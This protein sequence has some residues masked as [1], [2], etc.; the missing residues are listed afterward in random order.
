MAASTVFIKSIHKSF[1]P[2]HLFSRPCQGTVIVL[3]HFIV[4]DAARVSCFSRGFQQSCAHTQ[5]TQC[6]VHRIAGP[7]Y[8]VPSPFVPIRETLRL[9]GNVKTFLW[10]IPPGENPSGWVQIHPASF[11]YD[12]F[13][14]SDTPKLRKPTGITAAVKPSSCCSFLLSHA[15]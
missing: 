2:S 14:N 5:I 12:S 13:A 11:R 6:I 8:S 4:T 15:T 1:K 9:E 3:T 10:G 7:F